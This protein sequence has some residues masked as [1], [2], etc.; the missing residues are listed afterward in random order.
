MPTLLHIQSSPRTGRSYSLAAAEAFLAAYR[1]QRPGAKVDQ[2][3]LWRET[4]PVFNGATIDAKYAVLGGV[5]HNKDQ[6]AAWRAVEGVVDRL[7]RADHVLIS[8]P[9]WNFGVP[10]VLK[11]YIDVVT[12]PGL[13]F[14]WSPDKGYQGLVKGKSAVVIYS[15]AGSYAP[16][17]GAEGFDYQRPYLEHWLRFIGFEAI[18]SIHVAPTMAD[19]STVSRAVDEA[20]AAAQAAAGV[21]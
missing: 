10:Y 2:L 3:D 16:G 8:L 11:H 20:K 13:T 9:M 17:S 21:V 7:K 19:G 5:K 6:E 1:A 14:S 18:R 4:L 15:S 12:Q